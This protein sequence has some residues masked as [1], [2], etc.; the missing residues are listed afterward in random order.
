MGGREQP[1]QVAEAEEAIDAA[2]Q[3]FE[4]GSYLVL[5]DE[6]EQRSL[7]TQVFLKPDS[8]VTFLRLTMLAGG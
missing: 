5:I 6:N 1:P 4:D 7:D 3:A 8:R 2:L